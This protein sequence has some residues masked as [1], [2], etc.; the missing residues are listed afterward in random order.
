MFL[1]QAAQK[2]FQEK[3]QLMG[4]KSDK[5]DSLT[6][7]DRLELIRLMVPGAEFDRRTTHRENRPMPSM[8][9][10]SYK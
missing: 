10:T 4:I 9:S 7:P 8:A 5:F 1:S 2:E 3:V 6:L